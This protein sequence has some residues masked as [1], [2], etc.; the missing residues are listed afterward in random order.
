MMLSKFR[1][2]GKPE[3][4]LPSTKLIAVVVLGK[5]RFE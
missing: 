5:R 3:A 2:V 1:L 4:I